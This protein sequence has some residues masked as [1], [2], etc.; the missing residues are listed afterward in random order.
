MKSYALVMAFA[1][2]AAQPGFSQNLIQ[3]GGFDGAPQTS[4]GN[5]GS[6]D[7]PPWFFATIGSVATVANSH[8][9]VAVDGPGGY[10]YINLGPE[11]DASGAGAGVAQYYLDSGSAPQL[12]WQYFTP[13]CSGTATATVFLTNRE[14]HGNAGGTLF[15]AEVPT[16][17][18]PFSSFPT[19]GGLSIISTP[20]PMQRFVPG[21]AVLTG[22]EAQ[23][24]ADLNARHQAER[25]RFRL[26]AFD[27]QT[28]AWEP[29]TLQVPVLAG[30]SY[31]LVAELGHSV[32]MDNASVV[33]DCNTSGS[34]PE[35]PTDIAPSKIS[36]T[37][38]C[39]PNVAGQVNGQVGQLWDCQVDVT[40][41]QA[42][43]AGSLSVQDLYS[44]TTTTS[45]QVINAAS[46]SGNFACDTAGTC[47]IDGADFDASAAET[48]T[49]QLF[50]TS[51]SGQ[52]SY[53][54]K[55]CVAGTYTASNGTALPV[56]GNCVTGQWSPRV[57]I[58]KTCAPIAPTALGP[59][60]LNCALNVTASD[61][62]T[63]T[64]VFAADLFGPMPPAVATVQGP[65]M[66]ITSTESWSCA[67]G[68]QNAPGSIGGCSLS[69]LG[70]LNAG[71]ASTINVSFVFDIDQSP[72]QV[73]NCPFAGAVPTSAT[74]NL[75]K[76]K[77]SD[78]RLQ[79]M[80]KS[81]KP[82]GLPDSCVLVDV[83]AQTTTK[84]E[85]LDVVKTCRS[86]VVGQNGG[87]AGH[88]WDCD[89]AIDLQPAPFS[90]TFTLTE[91]ASQISNGQ[92][93]FIGAAVPCTGLQTD[94]LTCNIDG[95]TMASPT[96]VTVQLFAELGQGDDAVKWE[97]CATGVA[98]SGGSSLSAASCVNAVIEPSKDDPVKEI[99]LAKE[100]G[101][102]VPTSQNGVEGLGWNCTVRVT[103]SLVPFSGS[104]T[105]VDNASGIN[106]SPNAQI[107]NIL[108]QSNAWTCLPNTPT[109]LAQCTIN[110]AD[111]DPS[112]TEVVQFT[113][114]AETGKEPITWNN[115][116]SGAYTGLGVK[117]Q[118]VKGNCAG[119]TWTPRDDDD[120][121]SF[122]IAKTCEAT[123]KRQAFNSNW[124]Q[125][126]RCTITV[127]TNGV[128][129]TDLLSVA[130]EL[131]YGTYNGNA[132]MQQITSTDPWMC[133]PAPYGPAGQAGT[134]PPVCGIMG[135]QFP[136][137]AGQSSLTVDF[138]LLGGA[139]DVTGAKNCVGLKLGA[140]PAPTPAQGDQQS[141]FELIAPKAPTLD[142]VKTCKPAVQSGN[143]WTAKCEVTITGSGLQPGQ[144][145]RVTD[146]LSG[147]GATTVSA[148]SFDQGPLVSNN[149]GGLLM[150]GMQIAAC[151]LTT[152]N[153]IASGG[154]ITLPYTAVLNAVG[155]GLRK[156]P[157]Q[158][159]AF[160][161]IPA[162]AL[163]APGNPGD[164]ACVS[165][166][167]QVRIVKGEDGNLG[168]A[169]PLKPVLP[170][171]SVSG[172]FTGTPS[173][174]GG[175]AVL[176]PAVP[177]GTGTTPASPT[178]PPATLT[179]LQENVGNC[180]VNRSR[181][182]YECTMRISLRNDGAAPYTG[183][184]V[185][186][187]RFGRPG[188]QAVQV[189][190][191][192]GWSCNRPVGDVVPCIKSNATLR[193]GQV[194]SFD[195][196]VVVNGQRDGGQ[197]RGCAAL[198]VSNTAQSRVA[199]A[200][201][202][203]NQRGLN[204]G[205]VDGRSGPRTY[206]ALAQ[207]QGQ[208]GLPA[209][210]DF[211]DKLFAALG[212]AVGTG[213]PSCTQANLP[214]MPAPALQCDPQTTVAA[215]DACLCRFEGMRNTSATSCG[216]RRGAS[217]V[218]GKGC[219]KAQVQAPK[220]E[221]TPQPVPETPTIETGLKCDPKTTVAAGDGCLCRF[222]GMRKTSNT[223]CGCANGLPLVNGRCIPI[224]LVPKGD[225][226][227]E[228]GCLIELNGI[229]IK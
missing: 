53:A 159:C 22:A 222:E 125:P 42:P 102:L 15:G 129:F 194:D 107:V 47:Q 73:A 72:A 182:T 66:N 130:E 197:I 175:G 105:F 19:D 6:A 192:A 30:Q 49:Y 205:P 149:C 41:P 157:A 132:T 100:C 12:A 2:F 94:R 124:F 18:E 171:G 78:P 63:D 136:H 86:P 106:G 220:P 203:M 137:A 70:M 184:I 99:T 64:S 196:A 32:N 69:A 40:V 91:D 26:G 116:V 54:L 65:M 144:Q 90:G 97:N 92:A 4:F 87:I 21:Y 227:D 111:F 8:N 71:G 113:L 156:A 201:T 211:D 216:C 48:L 189:V 221:V 59:Y 161:D 204:A 147:S 61:M 76:Q 154:S 93:Q 183:P 114:F 31:A 38:S 104:F 83:P 7:L 80:T 145:F 96:I 198:G 200:Q 141:C 181:Q 224:D 52:P 84:L 33:M 10:D 214:A 98:Q 169:G 101:R 57:D 208:L 212:I 28:A 128:P 79:L 131:T 180:Q 115:C 217:F 1:M 3:D 162:A 195:I 142:L 44:N 46:V 155:G 215:G 177:N 151:D 228:K 139:A 20:A 17:T 121:P 164:K 178:P 37:K 13:T 82:P 191:G 58:S 160:V 173:T 34:P 206:A 110:G 67:D 140:V 25:L 75:F 35:P 123:G 118:P 85:K 122:D 81:A 51:L 226:S 14:G 120:K 77:S 39:T 60:T 109:P 108:A 152:D 62:A 16:I 202:I 174:L 225:G 27:T 218:A 9:L 68:Q 213:A 74:A 45:G 119:T 219:V 167:L 187:D 95:A 188:V 168:T 88:L 163:H 153:L 127:T 229:C 133:A 138:M 176:D 36:L 148:G 150:Q 24:V 158:N 29:M 56:A 166:P 172:G 112:G 5:K 207:L 117:D 23:A 134:N 43:F 103:A 11:S 143:Q 209:S 185:L 89:I 199:L 186:T 50:V 170:G 193:S 55:N 223:A 146:E 165:I 210:R 190:S 179:L 135:A 126:Y